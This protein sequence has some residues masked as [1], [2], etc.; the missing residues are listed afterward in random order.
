[1]ASLASLLQRLLL[2]LLLVCLGHLL[3]QPPAEEPL[4]D[5]LAALHLASDDP[6]QHS[7][8]LPPAQH[9]VA[10]QGGHTRALLVAYPRSPTLP[11][12]S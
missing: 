5:L 8:H 6:Q 7:L 10:S 9:L 2:L 4:G 11:M 3:L 12:P 1:M